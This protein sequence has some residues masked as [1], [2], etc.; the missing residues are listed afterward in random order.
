MFSRNRRS[1]AGFT[2]V[3]LLV[4]IGIIAVLI[5]VLLPALGA[6]R[7]QSRSVACQSNLRQISTA[8]LMYAQE[9]KWFVTYLPATGTTPAQD[10]KE[11]LY[12]YLRQGKNNTDTLGNQVWTCPSNER[13]D[14]EASYG[15]N[16]NLNGVRLTKIRRWSETVE[17]CDGGLM[18][19]PF[20]GAP[21]LATHM[22]PPSATDPKGTA[23]RPN[24]LRHPK[25]TICVGF[26]DG[27]GK[28][29]P[30][31]P[32]FYSGIVGAWAGNG[33]ADPND[34]NYKDDLWDLR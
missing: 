34:P 7:A 20:A 26:V 6:A 8:A 21:G 15:F 14:V 12:P 10:R 5:G 30:M 3:E 33:V 4:V 13:T 9:K 18:E 1:R 23:C 31:K 27:H 24:H 19:K 2:L 28:R 16:T 32:P 22:W 11:L 29:L 25:R 17:V